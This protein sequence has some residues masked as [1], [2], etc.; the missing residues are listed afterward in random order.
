MSIENQQCHDD[1]TPISVAADW[2]RTTASNVINATK[3]SDDVRKNSR[4]ALEIAR[5]FKS[6]RNGLAPIHSMPGR[7][8]ERIPVF[9]VPTIATE[10][11]ND[12]VESDP[13]TPLSPPTIPDGGFF[14]TGIGNN[15]VAIASET[16]IETLRYGRRNQSV[17][18]SE[19]LTRAHIDDVISITLE[20]EKAKQA[21][22]AEQ[23]KHDETRSALLQAKTKNTQSE[24][25]IEK[26]LNDMETK[27][28]ND[29][30]KILEL[31]NELRRTQLR[32]RAA[33]EDA[34]IALD[35]ARGN[36]E[37]RHQTE[38]SLATAYGEIQ[39]LR[40]HVHRLETRDNKDLMYNANETTSN[41][42][43]ET[44][45]TQR[46]GYSNF[47]SFQ[48]ASELSYSNPSRAL[49]AAGTEIV[50]QY[51]SPVAGSNCVISIDESIK[52][53]AEVSRQLR[54]RLKAL[55]E[56]DSL[57]EE[58]QDETTPAS[59]PMLR[60]SPRRDLGSAV[61]ALDICRRTVDV[62]KDSGRRLNLTG[63]WWKRD[64]E[65]RH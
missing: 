7:L 57:L 25:Q 29:A 58:V 64:A 55:E 36:A 48:N 14:W 19:R 1:Q 53:A 43:Q 46:N 37:K 49:V 42:Y 44:P 11:T 4:A 13:W 34:Q 16:P 28:E 22:E 30:R 45:G 17:A 62:L 32:E 5:M 10:F 23:M 54:N 50:R 40:E 21:L 27:R 26:L 18:T 41:S 63:R 52:A 12:A 24:Y 38:A 2:I 59:S 60:R 9:D 31:E 6:Q 3:E 47:G 35:L 8:T 65:V 56:D 33:A 51:A 61:E 15:A 20:L 39:L